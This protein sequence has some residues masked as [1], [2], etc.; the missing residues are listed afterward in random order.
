VRSGSQSS[1]RRIVLGGKA[2]SNAGVFLL[3][4]NYE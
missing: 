2:A 1:H 4:S 3:A